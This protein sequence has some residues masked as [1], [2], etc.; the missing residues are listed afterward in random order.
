MKSRNPGSPDPARQALEAF[1]AAG[2]LRPIPPEAVFGWVPP[3]RGPDVGT[4]R[5]LVLKR[6]AMF[7]VV[8]GR[9][10]VVPPGA[11]ELGL[12]YQDTR[13]LSYY[14]LRLPSESCSELSSNVSTHYVSQIDLSLYEGFETEDVWEAGRAHNFLHLQRRQVIT[15]VFVDEIRL[16]NYLPYRVRLWLEVWFTADF[17]DL[18]EA[19]GFEREA[20]GQYFAPCVDGRQVRLTYQGK[21]AQYYQTL[22]SFS[23]QP[24]L[25][26]GQ[27]ARWELSL[28]PSQEIDLEITVVPGH[29]PDLTLALPQPMKFSDRERRVA[30]DYQFWEREC[31]HVETADKVFDSALLQARADLKAL[32]LEQGDLR[33]IAAGVPW[34]VAPFGR[35][36]LITAFQSLM[37][38][39]G[40]A[41]DSL[42]F[43]AH[44][45]GQVVDDFRAEAPGK[46]MHEMRSGELARIGQIRHTP[47]YG[48]VDATPLFIILLEE[49]WRWTHDS[50][51]VRDLLPAA[52]RA[53]EWL[54]STEAWGGDPDGDGFIEYQ[55]GAGAFGLLNQGWK[56]SHD[57]VPWPD[58]RLAEPPIALVE[59]QGYVAD[60][61]QRL[62]NLL[63]A[64]GG[65]P[66]GV[67]SWETRAKRLRERIEE[68]FWLPDQKSY[69]LALDGRKR[70]VPTLTSNPGHLLFSRV[71]HP[72][73]AR[74]M[75]D[76]LLGAQMFSGWGIRTLATGQR[77]YNPLSYHNGSVWPHDNAMIAMGFAYYDMQPRA[78]QVLE[79][80]FQASRSFEHLRPP[81][82]F[83][84]IGCGEANFPVRYPVACMPQAWASASWFLLLRA[85][86]GLQ[87]NAPEGRLDIMQPCLP[88][89]L[90]DVRLSNFRVG[91]SRLDL[92]F[93]R[94][95]ERA[96]VEVRAI[97]GDPMR[98]QIQI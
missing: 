11:A 13:Y 20:R 77:A 62:A 34:Y 29:G 72:Q 66:S 33:I 75:A 91:N 15:D 96:N 61:Y 50:D 36:A 92:V 98:V 17:A 84:G 73:R 94:K 24:V 41:R 65:D 6:G 42:R 18:F 97:E 37:V 1:E 59:V 25:L 39:P 57:G 53:A 67:A 70:P 60:A 85:I 55:G 69:A 80:I 12:F 56:D 40:L 54:I 49:Y 44:Y 2:G 68:H 89:W 28:E 71:I 93:F 27:H 10:N 58:Y 30:A 5:K 7:A 88:P 14:E 83:C 46:I 48:T 90:K 43:L 52:I 26:D 64:F 35:D 45:Q 23:P 51:S 82:L 63:R 76:K 86:L 74:L 16:I 87:P 78:L 95:G 4:G 19:R 3:A 8:N 22:L 32:I 21:D 47:Y 9:G 81:E 79:A 31:T 38:N